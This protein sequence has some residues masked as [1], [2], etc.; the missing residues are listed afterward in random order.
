[1]TLPRLAAISARWSRVPPLTV[2]VANIAIGLGVQ[3]SSASA[4]SGPTQAANDE[5][6]GD[7]LAAVGGVTGEM[8]E[9]LKAGMT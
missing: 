6:M 5:A 2:S 4:S 9:W 1:M 7:L 8:P 3:R